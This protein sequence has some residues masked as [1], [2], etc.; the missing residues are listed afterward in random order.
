MENKI[1]LGTITLG[2]K[3]DGLSGKKIDLN[4]Q[5]KLT[6]NPSE[7]VSAKN[8]KVEVVNDSTLTNKKNQVDKLKISDLKINELDSPKIYKQTVDPD[9][10]YGDGFQPEMKAVSS[11]KLKQ[12]CMKFGFAN[13]ESSDE[14]EL[15]SIQF[16]YNAV[17]E[18]FEND[19]FNSSFE[20]KDEN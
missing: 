13:D 16:D 4:F 10:K 9:K 19:T 12:R 2:N 14:D 17:K 3:S 6:L 8:V 15:E 5:I 20:D 11:K 7:E 1:N 18:N